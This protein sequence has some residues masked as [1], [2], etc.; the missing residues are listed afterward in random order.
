MVTVDGRVIVGRVVT[1]GDYRS[2]SLRLATDPLRPAQLTEIA[3]SEIETHR[4]SPE[5]PMPAG[6]LD[7]FSADEI[8]DLLAYLEQTPR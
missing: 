1:G 5:S 7:S 3:K 4:P 2:T 6:L 8:R